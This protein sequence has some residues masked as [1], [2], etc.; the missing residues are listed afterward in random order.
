MNN[1]TKFILTNII[2]AKMFFFFFL[3]RVTQK[4]R[5]VFFVK[6]LKLFQQCNAAL[7]LSDM[8]DSFVKRQ[9][10]IYYNNRQFKKLMLNMN[11]HKQYLQV[12][13]MVEIPRFYHFLFQRHSLFKTITHVPA[14][15]HYQPNGKIPRWP[16]G[17]RN[18]IT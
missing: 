12:L 7:S 6:I 16:L 17:T 11:L 3:L 15:S 13:C 1:V 8:L 2:T 5:T 9:I 10:R 14:I 18:E 4:Y